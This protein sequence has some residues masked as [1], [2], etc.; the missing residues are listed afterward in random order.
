[1]SIRVL[2]FS[3]I[4]IIIPRIYVKIHLNI[5]EIVYVI[6]LVDKLEAECVC[7]SEFYAT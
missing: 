6:V 7:M 5:D 1:M 2:V 4:I 3:I